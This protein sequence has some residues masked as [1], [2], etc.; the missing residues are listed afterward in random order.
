MSG[1]GIASGGNTN[2]PQVPETGKHE[3][4]PTIR[5]MTRMLKKEKK[6]G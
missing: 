1:K 4:I 2:H 5:V 3:G 6:K